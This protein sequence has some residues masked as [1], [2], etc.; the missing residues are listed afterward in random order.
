MNFFCYLLFR[1]HKIAST[2]LQ[3][4]NHKNEIKDLKNIKYELRTLNLDLKMYLSH[5]NLKKFDSNNEPHLDMISNKFINDITRNIEDY[6]EHKIPINQ[7]EKYI[8][9]KKRFNDRERFIL[10]ETLKKT[11][12]Y[13]YDLRISLILI[14]YKNIEN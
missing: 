14:L 13:L 3:C 8:V 12:D 4:C 6:K 7:I 2:A 9:K 10:F 5:V 11:K 1:L